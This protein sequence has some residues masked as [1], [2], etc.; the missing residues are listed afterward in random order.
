MIIFRK[1]ILEFGA[2]TPKNKAFFAKSPQTA[3]KN[4][5]ICQKPHQF[6]NLRSILLRFILDDSRD[7]S[8]PDA[9]Q[10]GRSCMDNL[11]APNNAADGLESSR[12]GA[13]GMKINFSY[14]NIRIILLRSK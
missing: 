9:R 8:G 6:E 13:T 4:Q 12:R 3:L 10:A 1:N 2:K 5:K 14:S 11:R 7:K